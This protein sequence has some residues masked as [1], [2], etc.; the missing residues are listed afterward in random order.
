MNSLSNI[1]THRQT[2]LPSKKKM[3]MLMYSKTLGAFLSYDR[4]N[5]IKHD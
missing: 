4:R 5:R 3:A 2:E 1:K